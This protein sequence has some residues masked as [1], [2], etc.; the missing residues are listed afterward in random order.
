VEIDKVLDLSKCL[1][2]KYGSL[3]GWQFGLRF[4]DRDQ[5]LDYKDPISFTNGCGSPI[6]ATIKDN[7]AASVELIRVS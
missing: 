3:R 7:R 2:E 1:Q 4:S 5:V 6:A